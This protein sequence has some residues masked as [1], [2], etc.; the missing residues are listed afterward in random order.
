MERKDFIKYSSFAILGLTVAP[1]AQILANS[2]ATSKLSV[3]ALSHIRHGLLPQMSKNIFTRFPVVFQLNEFKDG[4]NIN[5][6][7]ADIK[8]LSILSNCGEQQNLQL[9]FDG[10]QITIVDD[11]TSEEFRVDSENNKTF[12]IDDKKNLSLFWAKK[13]DSFELK[14]KDALYLMCMQGAATAN[15]Q[16]ISESNGLE[17]RTKKLLLEITENNTLVVAVIL[18]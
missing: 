11:K 10:Q 13:G 5:R 8:V 17:V 6:G 2:Q 1:T 12:P 9:S 16:T 4:I 15:K 14:N 7:N 3:N 18:T